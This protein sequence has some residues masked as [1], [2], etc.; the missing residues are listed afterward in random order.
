MIDAHVHVIAGD[1]ARYPVQP[2]PPAWPVVTGERLLEEMDRSGIERAMLV[3]SFF[4]Y[5]FDNS[6]AIDCAARAPDRFQVVAVIDQL[7]D[8]A[9]AVLTDLV[10]RHGVRGVRF[11]PKGMPDG[12]L[13][14]ARTFPVWERAGELGIPV[15]IA[16]EIQHL[17]P[18]PE[19]VSR[20][21]D[22]TVC[23]EHMWGV[24]VD[25]PPFAG[26]AE[27]RALAPFENVHLKLAPNND[28]AA[29]EAG[30]EPRELFA[31]LIDVFGLDRLLWGSNYPA[32]PARFG[33]Y[34]DRLEVMR[35][36]L[37]F[38]SDADQDAFFGGNAA[39]IWPAATP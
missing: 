24:E 28:W 19:V 17:A 14:D 26:L 18:M 15:T 5:G 25:R 16:A 33:G 9:P 37:A 3:Q 27:L 6:Y 10:E 21:P 32:H 13:W 34:P 4:T 29:R 38:L 7:A 39:R 2:D 23:F 20:F 30:F 22:V 35:E 36:D 11:M 1:P 12:V 31:H 8:D